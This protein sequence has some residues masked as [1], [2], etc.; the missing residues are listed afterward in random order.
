MN[1]HNGMEKEIMKTIKSKKL[2][3]KDYFTIEE[4]EGGIYLRVKKKT[5]FK[6]KLTLIQTMPICT[7]PWIAIDKTGHDE[8]VGIE[9]IPL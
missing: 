8:L 1:L 4:N 2:K 7:T 9:I 5:K 3:F 6:G